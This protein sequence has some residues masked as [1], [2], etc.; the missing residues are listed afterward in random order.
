MDGLGR[1]GAGICDVD[2]V[3]AE[4]AA[5]AVFAVAGGAVGDE[6]LFGGERLSLGEGDGGDG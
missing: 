1:G 2:D 5:V 6:R 3:G 4:L